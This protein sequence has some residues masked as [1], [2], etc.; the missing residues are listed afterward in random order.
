MEESKAPSTRPATRPQRSQRRRALAFGMRSP[1][2]RVS[3][4]PQAPCQPCGRARARSGPCEA[5]PC[6]STAT[7]VA[8][9]QRCGVRTRAGRAPGLAR[10]LRY[11]RPQPELEASFHE[12]QAT[13][14]RHRARRLL[15]ADRLGGLATRLH[16][17]LP[18]PALE[19]G[20]GAPARRSHHLAQPSSDLDAGRLARARA[21][22]PAL[23]AADARVR[24]GRTAA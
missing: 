3:R 24:L 10:R 16:R 11:E 2:F 17:P 14:A 1:A 15:R 12:S 21:R 18:A 4:T 13:R 5:C 23:R 19:L 22:V 7:D 6:R 8:A 20:D 9:L